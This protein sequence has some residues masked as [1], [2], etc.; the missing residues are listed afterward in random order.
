MRILTAAALLFVA[1]T[2]QAGLLTFHAIFE[3]EGAGG[4][5]GSGSATV[6][7]DDVSHL[8]SYAGTFAG[9]SGTTTAAHFHC[10]TATPFTGTAGIA[11]DTPTLSGFPLGVK[12]GSFD[13][14]L[15]LNDPLNFTPGFV[16][17]SGGTAAG[18][19]ARLLD[20]FYAHTAYLNI[21]T[22]T[23]GSGEIRGFIVPEP[24]SAAL[25]A[26][27]LAGLGAAGFARKR[28]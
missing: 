14:S 25:A 28:S 27:A 10:C 12:D 23:F 7:F 16:T 3:P 5:T 26:L 18:A 24:P 4:R 15:D 21:H 17:A 13:S 19:R 2:A 6:T 22:S 11:V 9:L 1:S 8:L 20:G